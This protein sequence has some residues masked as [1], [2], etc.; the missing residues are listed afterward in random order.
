MNEHC[1]CDDCKDSDD[2]CGLDCPDRRE[3]GD[4]CQGCT[5][6]YDAALDREHDEMCALGYK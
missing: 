2:P 4:W 1:E 6:D 3:K 5:E